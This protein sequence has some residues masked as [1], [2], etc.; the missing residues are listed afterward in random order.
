MAVEVAHIVPA[1][2]TEIENDVAGNPIFMGRAL[3]GSLTSSQVWQIRQLTFDGAN[4]L[5][6][7]RFANGSLEFN[8]KWDDRATLS[9]S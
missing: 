9:Y 7:I 6:R 4:N 1:Y 2:I 3:L 8:C 5:L